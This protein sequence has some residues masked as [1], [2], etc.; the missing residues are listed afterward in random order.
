MSYMSPINR[1]LHR[2]DEV[3]GKRRKK[4][5]EKILM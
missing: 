1:E 2:Y 4:A 5:I 3:K